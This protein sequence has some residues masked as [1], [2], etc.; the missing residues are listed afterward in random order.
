MTAPD[1]G[2]PGR[3][4]QLDRQLNPPPQ[5]PGVPP[6]PGTGELHVGKTGEELAQA[7]FALNSGQGRTEAEV[8]ATGEGEML[9]RI[10]PAYVETLGIVEHCWVAVG[11]SKVDHHH[12]PTPDRRTADDRVRPGHPCSQ[13][14]GES[15]RRISSTAPGHSDG[16]AASISS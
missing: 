6:H 10:G 2:V 4:T 5:Y 13:L 9:A 3:R 11:G 15:R 16:S 12:L 1:N 8:P 14:H 7:D